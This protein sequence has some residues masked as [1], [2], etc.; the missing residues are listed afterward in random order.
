MLEAALHVEPHQDVAEVEEDSGLLRA[1]HEGWEPTAA[2][3]ESTAAVCPKAQGSE[4]RIAD[5]PVGLP[6]SL[7]PGARATSRLSASC[8]PAQRSCDGAEVKRCR[9][10]LLCVSREAGT[11]AVPAACVARM[12]K[13]G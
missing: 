1:S 10:D 11:A 7:A 13:M 6:R 2:S 9:E 4:G 3:R 5:A 12:K 8:T